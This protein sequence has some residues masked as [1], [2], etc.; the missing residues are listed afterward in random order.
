MIYAEA[1]N[2]YTKSPT[3]VWNSTSLIDMLFPMI[4]LNGTGM[5]HKIMIAVKQLLKTAFVQM[6][7]P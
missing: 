4:I 1:I 2:N 7:H 3:S 6:R 5:A